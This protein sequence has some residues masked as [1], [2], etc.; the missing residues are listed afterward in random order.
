VIISVRKAVDYKRR[1]AHY[2]RREGLLT[3]ETAREEKGYSLL[4]LRD[5]SC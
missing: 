3:V 4:R 5:K 1:A 2:E